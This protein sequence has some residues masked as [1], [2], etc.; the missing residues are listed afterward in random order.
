MPNLDINTLSKDLNLAKARW[1]ARQTPQSL[2]TDSQK[3]ALLGV[4]F[5]K[6]YIDAAAAPAVQSKAAPAFAPAVDWRNRNGNHV[7]SVKDQKTAALACPFAAPPW[8]S[9]WPRSR[10]ASC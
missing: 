5:S 8:W 4:I 1:T 10:K 9:P 3:M 2:L 7:T 6:E